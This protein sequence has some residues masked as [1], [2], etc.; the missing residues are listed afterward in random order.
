MTDQGTEISIRVIKRPVINKEIL[1]LGS[2]YFRYKRMLRLFRIKYIKMKL[3]LIPPYLRR[4]PLLSV[5][6][7]SSSRLYSFMV[8]STLF[9]RIIQS[10]HNPVPSPRC[11]FNRP[12]GQSRK[13]GRTFFIMKSRTYK[14]TTK[15][16]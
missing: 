12:K 6:L 13:K 5:C 14:G 16:G 2:D 1:L 3:N 11:R 10:P 15:V 4:E 9:L 8:I 7:N